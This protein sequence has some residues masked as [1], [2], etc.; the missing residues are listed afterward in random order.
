MPVLDVEKAMRSLRKSPVILKA[1]L[2]GVSDEQARHATDGPDGWSVTFVVCHL[3]DFEDVYLAR[4][5]MMLE[6]DHPHFPRV[7]HESLVVVNDY[8]G[9]SML[10]VLD[11]WIARRRTFYALLS[12]LREDQWARVG[13][14]PTFGEGTV[15]DFALTTALHDVNHIEQIVRAL[16]AAEALI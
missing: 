7:D 8:A 16:G 2:N 3:H 5:R 12:G 14:H 15:L 9:K 13:T 6:H 4:T 1:L 11:E 10:A